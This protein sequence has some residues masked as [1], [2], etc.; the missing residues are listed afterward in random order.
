[1]T[2]KI[3]NV[4]YNFSESLVN[5]QRYLV[6]RPNVTMKIFRAFLNFEANLLRTDRWTIS[7]QAYLSS[8]KEKL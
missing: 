6:K 7:G 2:V 3:S 8:L 1:M 4:N 5:F